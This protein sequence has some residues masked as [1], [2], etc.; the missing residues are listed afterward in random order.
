MPVSGTLKSALLSAYQAQINSTT[1]QPAPITDISDAHATAIVSAIKDSINSNTTVTFALTA[2]NG[3]VTG[4]I[5][6][7]CTAS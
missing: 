4:T 2:P 7:N 5:T 1:A 6:L 3:P